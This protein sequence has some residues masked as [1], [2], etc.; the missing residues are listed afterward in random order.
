MTAMKIIKNVKTALRWGAVLSLFLSAD[1]LAQAGSFDEAVKEGM[2]HY[3][4]RQYGPAIVKFEEA[5]ALNPQPELIYNVARAYEKSVKRDQAITAYQRFLTLEGTTAALRSK[6]LDAITALRREKVALRAA[7][8]PVATSPGVGDPAAGAVTRAPAPRSSRSHTVEWVL[9]GGGAAAAAV[10]GVF[11]LLAV[12]ANTDFN[13]RKANG[14]PRSELEGKKTTI[15]NNA[16]VADVLVGVGVVSALA[17]IIMYATGGDD[18]D[19]A[20]TPVFGPN[21]AAMGVAGRF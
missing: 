19:L 18:E 14:A 21:Y 17:G 8:A 15:E 2:N 7:M 9:I 1:A 11:G 6:A 16:L 20:I 3:R 12:Q 5:Y 10:G 4:A 13:D